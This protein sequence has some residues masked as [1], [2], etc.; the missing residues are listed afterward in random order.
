MRNTEAGHGGRI[1]LL[2]PPKDADSPYMA[3]ITAVL[4]ALRSAVRREPLLTTPD[5][6][7]IRKALLAP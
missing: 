1:V 6:A 5:A 2:T 3:F 4:T 7:A